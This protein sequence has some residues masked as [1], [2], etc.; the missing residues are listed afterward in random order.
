[1]TRIQFRRNPVRQNTEALRTYL[2]WRSLSEER[3][4][5]VITTVV[6]LAVLVAILAIGF[7][8]LSGGFTQHTV[9][10]SEELLAKLI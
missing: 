8:Y 2:D 5:K 6:G 10:M 1:M 7:T 3:Q 9:C 4:F